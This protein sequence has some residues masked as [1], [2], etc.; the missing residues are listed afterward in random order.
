VIPRDTSP[1]AHRAQLDWYRRQSPSKKVEIAARMS[2]D[3]REVAAAGIRAR[4]PDYST[5]DVR[6]ALF[7]LLIG[8]PLFHRV[9]P[10]APLLA[11]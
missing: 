3:A 5:A 11:P 9:W 2:E 10:D 1:A 8:D 7:R 6:W 4:H